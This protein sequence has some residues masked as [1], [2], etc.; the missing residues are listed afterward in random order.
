MPRTRECG[1]VAELSSAL[2]RAEASTRG[3][4]VDPSDNQAYLFVKRGLLE[5]KLSVVEA[6]M[7]YE[8]LFSEQVTQVIAKPTDGKRRCV[9]G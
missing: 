7:I 4:G 8:S 2:E 5:G 6:E 9:S 3:E 1:I